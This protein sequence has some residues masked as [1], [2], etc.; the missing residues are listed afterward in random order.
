MFPP[1]DAYCRL[2]AELPQQFPLIQSSTLTA[3]TIAFPLPIFP[4][5]APTC[6]F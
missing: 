4:S 6:L 2:V 3:Y 1:L 5:A